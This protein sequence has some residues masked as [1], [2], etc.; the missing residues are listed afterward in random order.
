[1]EI[2]PAISR[3]VLVRLKRA[4]GQLDGYELAPEYPMTVN[5]SKQ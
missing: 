4:R 2:D 5:F 3:D 1:M